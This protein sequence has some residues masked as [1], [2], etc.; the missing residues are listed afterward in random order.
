MTGQFFGPAAAEVGGV[1]QGTRT[2]D[3]SVVYGYFGGTK[4]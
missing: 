1:L 2:G 3:N 4:Q